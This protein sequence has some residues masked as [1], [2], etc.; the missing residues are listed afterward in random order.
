LLF[1]YHFICIDVSFY[2]QSTALILDF[3]M[4]A[5]HHLGFGMTS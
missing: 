3:Q 2:F 5:V 1:L 4:A